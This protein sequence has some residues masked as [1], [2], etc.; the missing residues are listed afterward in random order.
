ME[1]QTFLTTKIPGEEHN[2]KPKAIIVSY[3]APIALFFVEGNE[4][5]TQP[6]EIPVPSA[7]KTRS[8][9]SS[10]VGKLLYDRVE[11]W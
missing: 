3:G 11:L 9:F 2:S 7:A 6:M 4:N 8:S 5:I 1:M 10:R